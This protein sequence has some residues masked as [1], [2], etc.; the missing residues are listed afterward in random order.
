MRFL[1][2]T[3]CGSDRRRSPSASTV[4][5][6]N[7]VERRSTK[8]FAKGTAFHQIVG[9]SRKDSAACSVPANA[10]SDLG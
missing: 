5:E 7:A 2:H 8:Y 6:G 9:V 1:L 10:V 4:V 3:A